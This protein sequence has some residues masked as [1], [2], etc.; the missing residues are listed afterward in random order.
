MGSGWGHEDAVGDWYATRDFNLKTLTVR[1]GGKLP[2]GWQIIQN[3][4]YL[5][6]LFGKDCVVRKSSRELLAEMGASGGEMKR[7]PGRPRR[8]V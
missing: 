8:D 6:N 7:S 1:A 5:Q 3:I 4:K 2:E